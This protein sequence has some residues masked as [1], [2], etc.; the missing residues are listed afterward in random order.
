MSVKNT[1]N[2]DRAVNCQPSYRAGAIIAEAHVTVFVLSYLFDKIPPVFIESPYNVAKNIIFSI[3]CSFFELLFFNWSPAFT[4]LC[5]MFKGSYSRK[6]KK[7][8]VHM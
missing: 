4:H 1:N 7:N 5:N 8:D 2:F 3:V 6:L